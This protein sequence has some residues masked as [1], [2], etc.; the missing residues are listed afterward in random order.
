MRRSPSVLTGAALTAVA[1]GTLGLGSAAPAWA[2][3]E[4][5]LALSLV[6]SGWSWS[7]PAGA[8]L[9]AS[10]VATAG[11]LV[12]GYAGDSAGKPSAKAYLG[13]DLSAL[14]R[15]ASIV[16]A[17][18]TLTLDPA[19]R[20]NVQP[21]GNVLRAC[22]TA[23]AWQRGEGTDA[24]KQPKDDCTVSTLGRLDATG[25]TY[26]FE[27]APLVEALQA[28][29]DLG[30]V[31]GPTAGYVAPSGAPFQLSFITAKT[32]AAATV[33]VPDTST[34]PT[35]EPVTPPATTLP[36]P[37]SPGSGFSG[38]PSFGGG[39]VT[40]VLPSPA[41]NPVVAPPQTSV[42]L[43]RVP[44]SVA[45]RAEIRAALAQN[46]TPPAGLWLAGSLGA[47]V[48]GLVSWA[49]GDTNSQ[50][51]AVRTALR[52]RESA[53][54]AGQAARA[55]AQRTAASPSIRRRPARSAGTAGTAAD[56][57]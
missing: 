42:A 15:E 25:T 52:R 40:G 9:P 14:P 33:Q 3:V 32:T 2:G 37:A 24:A 38:G 21:T 12:V 6:A 53:L 39:T 31:I 34:P 51:R 5:T 36:P 44:V 20:S 10:T 56:L 27:I 30:L 17:P 57:G 28:N 18:L 8:P 48:L 23:G 4:R 11:D 46:A 1:L 41:P 43:P 50:R 16:T 13:L 47:L 19:V 45:S 55:T 49:A 35:E 29:A 26:R 7:A 22:L 54:Q